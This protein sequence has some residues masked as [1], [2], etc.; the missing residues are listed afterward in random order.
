M[1]KDAPGSTAGESAS[2]S[3]DA[4]SAEDLSAELSEQRAND[5]KQRIHVRRTVPRPE[6][7]KVSV[8]YSA[9]P[10][11]R[12]PQTVLPRQISSLAFSKTAKS[13]APDE[14]AK[15][16]EARARSLSE[17]HLA[18]AECYAPPSVIVDERHNILHLSAE[19]GRYLQFGAGMPSKNLLKVVL[20][21]LRVETRTALFRAAQSSGNVTISNVSA[22]VE[23]ESRM[24]DLHVRPAHDS[25]SGN[26]YFLVLFEEKTSGDAAIEAP[27]HYEE[28]VRNLEQELEATRTQLSAMVE[29]YEASTEELKASNEELQAMNEELRSA[30]EELETG[31]EELQSVNEELITVNQEL[32]ASVEDLA[33]ANSDLQNLIGSTDIGTLFLNRELRI[34]RFTPRIQELFNIVPSD[35]G[36]P[37][38]DLTRKI[39]YASLPNDAERV[40]LDLIPIEREVRHEN[41]QYFLVRIIPYR[42]SEERIDG[43]VLNFVDITKRKQSETELRA[44]VHAREQQARLFDTTLS[45]IADFAFTFDQEGRF[46]FAN[47]PLA[48][49]LG[50]TPEA[51]VGKNFFDLGYPDD[52]A[53]KLQQQ[54]RAVFETKEIVRDE[55]PFTD[56]SGRTGYYEYILRPVLNGE[57]SVETVVGSTRDLTERQRAEQALA[58]SETRFRE[59]A[60]NS[61]D[62][63]WIIDA[64]NEKLEYL[65]PAYERIW[66]EARG[67]V[68]HDF[69]RWKELLHPDDRARVGDTLRQLLNGRRMTVEYR[70]VRPDDGEVRWIRDTGFP[71]YDEKGALTRVAGVGRDITPEKERQE[72][73][74]V[75]QQR[76]RL[77]V[78]GAPEYAMFIIGLNNRITYWSAGAERIFGWS[79][80]EAVGQPGTLIFTPED[81]AIGQEIKEIETAARDGVA[82]DR[83][84]HMRKDGSRVW[85]DGVMRRLVEENGTLR[86]FAKIARDATDRREAEE[87]LQQSHLD[88]ERRVAK[89]TADL[90]AANQ[91]LQ[92]EIE[93]RVKLEQEILQISEREK[94]RIGQDLH[95]GLC[96]ELAAAAF[97]L[98]STA[99]KLGPTHRQESV[100]LT[101]AAQIVNANVG[102]ARDLA[103]G[104]HPVELNAS[105]LKNALSELAYRINQ[106]VPCRFHCPHA[107]RVP[108][109]TL[110]L[111]LY[112]I[113]QE[114]AANAVEHGKPKEITISLT[115]DRKGINLTIHDRGKGMAATAGQ[116]RMGMHIMKYRANAIGGSLTVNSKPND[117]TT[118]TCHV[119]P[120]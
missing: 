114:A 103:R 88:L 14:T 78:E 20:P 111:N 119:P 116:G 21:A 49:L 39:D 55:T 38:S 104:L 86:G 67:A 96:Q 62:V 16:E 89:R 59:F 12:L 52:L 17:L 97:F 25:G 1:A 74:L 71:I 15:P 45:S 95:D 30:T 5:K 4:S 57:G 93:R 28:S 61:A 64:P 63:F 113:A 87:K 83:R 2:P 70:I 79:A 24:I 102:L 109:E 84:W 6:G 31:R 37:L 112:R 85:V 22:E 120:R 77:L 10:R 81:L 33:G 106:E 32:K 82:S 105:G 7:V 42:T 68:M 100:A 3:Q 75:T 13:A 60:E 110:A 98:Q 47:Q 46:L 53:A 108:G 73:L 115:R 66:G 8:P 99:R 54:I 27:V 36:R 41:G 43:V 76:F 51:V 58:E 34:K 50:L 69:A 107:V 44:A 9:V 117:G 56:L 80:E 18:L 94:R 65:N 72:A 91:K 26:D 48:N 29:Q 11:R 40:F 92:A 19:A 23:G 90:T 35:V 118:V 101:E